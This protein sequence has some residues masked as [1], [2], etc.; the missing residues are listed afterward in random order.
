MTKFYKKVTYFS[1]AGKAYREYIQQSFA[2]RERKNSGSVE[3]KK[4]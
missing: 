3:E 4:I 2:E 1:G